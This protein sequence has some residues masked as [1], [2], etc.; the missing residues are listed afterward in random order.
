MEYKLHP[1]AQGLIMWS[2]VY[3]QKQKGLF[4][5]YTEN[6]ADW[7]ARRPQTG[8]IFMILAVTCRKSM[9]MVR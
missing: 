7:P 1:P 9:S 3:K 5:F 6:F 8:P 2:M 4:R